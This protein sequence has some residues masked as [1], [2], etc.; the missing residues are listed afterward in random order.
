MAKPRV[1]L[2]DEPSLGLV[3]IIANEVRS[4]IKLVRD[5]FGAAVLLAEQNAS[6]LSVA[7]GGYIMHTGRIVAEGSIEELRNL[8]LMREIYLG[9]AR[10]AE[11]G[12]RPPPS[13]R[14]RTGRVFSRARRE[15]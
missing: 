10:G 14:E 3:P 9:G 6:L 5:R 15:L 11:A 12:A 1:L 13:F 2:V 4:I 8:A 7:D